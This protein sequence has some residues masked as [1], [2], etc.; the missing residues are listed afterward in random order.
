MPQLKS[1]TIVCGAN[2]TVGKPSRHPHVGRKLH[3]H[4]QGEK[5]TTTEQYIKEEETY[6]L[7][8]NDKSKAPFVVF[9]TACSPFN[10]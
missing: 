2:M 9:A 6:A 4:W 10:D 1:V 5:T 8:W 7:V 3:H